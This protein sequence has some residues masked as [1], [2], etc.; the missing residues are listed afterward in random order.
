ML[1]K[2][3][4]KQIIVISNMDSPYFEEGVFVL[5]PSVVNEDDKIVNE[6]NRIVSS[7][8]KKLEPILSLKKKRLIYKI[9]VPIISVFAII[10][11]SAL[12]F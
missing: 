3:K 5:K 11:L 2:Y 8:V 1:K 7:Y 4:N 10:C 9:I 6:A 12:I